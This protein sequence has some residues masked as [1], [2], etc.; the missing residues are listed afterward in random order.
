MNA[1][2]DCCDAEPVG[3]VAVVAVCAV[4]VVAV[5][6][7]AVVA[8]VEDDVAVEVAGVAVEDDVAVEVAGVAVARRILPPHIPTM[9]L[10]QT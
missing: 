4:A 7:V 5:C 9:Q 3:A 6:A 1:A 8:V 2:Q 10:T